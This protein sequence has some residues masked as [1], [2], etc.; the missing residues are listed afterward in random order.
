MSGVTRARI[1]AFYLP[2]F[3][4]IPEN[5]EWWGRGFTEWTNV[6]RAR[7]LFDGHYQP[8]VPAH[9]GYYDLRVSETREAQ[10]ELARAHGLE[11]FCYWHYWF[12]G[13][14]LLRRPFDEVLESG[15]PA[16]PFCL[17]WANHSWTRGWLGDGEI[18]QEQAHAPEDDLRHARWL[19]EAFSDRRYV[20]VDGR[21]LF[22]IFR[23]G[24]LPSPE[25]T[26]E[27]LRNECVRLGVA[28]PFLLGIN[29]YHD[30]DYRTL[31]FDG[32]VCF[33]PR[34]G[35][36]RELE[37]IHVE[38]QFPDLGIYDYI[39]VRERMMAVERAWPVYRSIVVSWDNTP[40]RKARGIVFPN[41]SPERFREGLEELIL[42]ASDR[43]HDDR[44]IFIDAW[45]EWAEGNHLEPDVR[46]GLGYLE[47]LREANRR[48]R[49]PAE[50]AR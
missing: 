11:G 44:L 6:A 30:I 24:D 46:Y 20:R 40:R 47:A 3:H 35:V 39:A 2:Q 25:R 18:L 49:M 15:R 37:P 4:P 19:A 36:L 23:P 12:R 1:L 38:A 43:P 50:V 28:E 10:A 16:F 42:E 33:E 45:N 8:H 34:L 7:P 9:L 5:D 22:L 29:S 27:L 21:P 32:T 14:R 41:S 31:G 26:V 17:A 13:K 48:P